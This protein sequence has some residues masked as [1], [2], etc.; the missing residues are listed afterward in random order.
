MFH[1]IQARIGK[2]IVRKYRKDPSNRDLENGDNVTFREFIDYLIEEGVADESANEHWRPISQLCQ[3]CLL[4]YTFIGKYEKF[5]DDA[6][7]ILKMIDAPFIQFP[8]NK[9]GRTADHLRLYFASLPLEKI[10]QLYDL[11]ELDFKLFGYDL[12]NVIGYDIG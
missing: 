3:P 2:Y 1:F 12:E 4:N 7:L 11:Y 9:S 10:K 8:Q 6:K 5:D